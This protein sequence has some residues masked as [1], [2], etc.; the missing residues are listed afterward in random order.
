MKHIIAIITV[1]LVASSAYAD[2]TAWPNSIVVDEQPLVLV[3]E[4]VRKKFMMPLYNIALYKNEALEL[5]DIV[6]SDEAKVLRLEVTSKLL[7][8]ALL[9]EAVLEGFKN[10]EG[11][12]EI[13]EDVR[14]YLT[15][16]DAELLQG[17][18]YTV[19]HDPSRGLVTYHND[20][21]LS[22]VDNHSFSEGMFNIWLGDRP[23][24][25]R[26]KRDLLGK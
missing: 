21:L 5:N 4:G 24:N 10:Y 20:Q 2:K 25:R 8:T 16:F 14:L 7:S 12:D 9:T 26:L 23:V 22:I 18:V 19:F 6:V 13:K 15:S 1:L 17:D 3:G 11:Y